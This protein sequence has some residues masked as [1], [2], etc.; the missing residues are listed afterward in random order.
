MSTYSQRARYQGHRGS[1]ALQLAVEQGTFTCT[2][3]YPKVC[4]GRVQE[5]HAP[6]CEKTHNTNEKAAAPQSRVDG[7]LLSGRYGSASTAAQPLYVFPLVLG[8]NTICPT[9]CLLCA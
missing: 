4:W 9:T 8:I 3:R 6:E 1:C 7:L 5:R 2:N